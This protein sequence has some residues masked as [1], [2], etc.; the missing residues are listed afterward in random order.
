M[1]GPEVLFSQRKKSTI[2]HHDCYC[3]F[4]QRCKLKFAVL[5]DKN[6]QVEKT[7]FW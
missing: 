3:S 7:K 1:E 2:G 5:I 6:M 4:V